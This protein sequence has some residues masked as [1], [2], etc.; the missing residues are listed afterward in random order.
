MNI[1]FFNEYIHYQ[2]KGLKDKAKEYVTKF[3]RSFENDA[4]KEL[5]TKEYLPTLEFNCNCRIRNE[6]FEEI[7]FPVLLNEY[8][9][10]DISSMIWLVKLEQN[11][12]TNNR[13]L[14]RINYKTVWEIIRE[15]YTIEPNN[16]E[17]TD[18]YLEYSIKQMDFCTHEYHCAGIILYGNDIAS[19]D[20]CILLLEEIVFIKNTLDRNKKYAAFINLCEYAIKDYMENSF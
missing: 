8:N 3:I 17:V 5:W 13:I 11:I 6:L 20:E 9:H 12:I 7:V 16:T 1:E 4:E 2:H 18:L 10:K 14:K 15:C 19:K